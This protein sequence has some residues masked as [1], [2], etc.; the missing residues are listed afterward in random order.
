MKTIWSRLSWNISTWSHHF[1]EVL[2]VLLIS[3]PPWSEDWD[4]VSHCTGGD[5]DSDLLEVGVDKQVR[6]AQPD[7]RSLDFVLCVVKIVNIVSEAV[8]WWNPSLCGSLYVVCVHM[9][10]EKHSAYISQV[11]QLMPV[12]PHLKFY[13]PVEAIEKRITSWIIASWQPVF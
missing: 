2:V 1:Y 6:R 13:F 8:T 11:G 3:N 10:T 7:L 5:S 4:S 9:E 12:L